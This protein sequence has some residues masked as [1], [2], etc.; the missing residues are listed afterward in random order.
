MVKSKRKKVVI[1]LKQHDKYLYILSMC[2]E[3]EKIIV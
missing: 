1:A 2:S 3:E